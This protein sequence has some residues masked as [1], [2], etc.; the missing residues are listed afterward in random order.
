[1]AIDR[2]KELRVKAGLSQTALGKKAGIT[3]TMISLYETGKMSLAGAPFETILALARALR[4][5]LYEL[6][7]IEAVKGFEEAAK[8]F[9]KPDP[10]AIRLWEAYKAL[11]EGPEKQFIRAKLLRSDDASNSVKTEE[12]PP[13]K[14]Q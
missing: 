7:G 4:C 2:L 5:T 8:T 12:K 1:M 10:E 9:D 13:P 11:P 3:H 14:E 6:T